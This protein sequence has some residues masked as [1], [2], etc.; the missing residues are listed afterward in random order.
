MTSSEDQ[1]TERKRGGFLLVFLLLV[2]VVS[3]IWY[4]AHSNGM[5]QMPGTTSGAQHKHSG[6]GASV[7]GG[8]PVSVATVTARKDNI[9]ITRQA[10]GT[11]TPAANVTVR[12]QINGLLQEIAFQEGQ[13]VQKGDYLAQIDPRPY[14]MA[15]EQ[16][17]GALQRDQALLGEA[18]LNLD[19]YRKLV[20]QDSIA[21][22]Q[23]DTQES[24]VE[25]YK[26]NVLT[27]QGQIDA[28]KLNLTYC[29]ITAPVAGRV[30]LRQVD[31]GN[32][33]QTSDANGIVS[34]TQLQPITVIFTLPEDDLPAVMKRLGDGATLTATAFD[35]TLRAKLAEGKLSAVDN[36]INT[37]TGTIKLRAEFDNKDN[38]L[39]PNQFVNITLLVDT[40]RDAVVVPSAAI[41]RGSPGTYVYRV[42]D[43]KTV[44]VTP[45]KLGATQGDNVA[46]TDGLSV[47]DIVVIEG[48]DKLRDGA[49]VSVK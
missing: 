28:A 11:V 22:Q 7:P 46:V 41:Q 2:V 9:D 25:Q 44:S 38:M 6:D 16:A 13:I 5:P 8:G 24:L 15:E 23:L 30:G 14:Q 33:A 26:G 18:Q 10:L 3:G 39:F 17:E 32:Y 20:K 48:A 35:R 12:T 1:P 47:G 42:K 36:Q 45:V 4:Y 43:D 49:A 34:I 29:H 21:K 31:A 19:R 37:S 27:D 40:L